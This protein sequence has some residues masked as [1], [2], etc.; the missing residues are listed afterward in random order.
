MIKIFPAVLVKTALFR[1]E[2]VKGRSGKNSRHTEAQKAGIPGRSFRPPASFP[3]VYVE[4]T[5]LLRSNE[6]NYSL[7]RTNIKTGT[8][9]RSFLVIL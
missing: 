6:Y 1:S 2:V 3:L 9:E 5:R 7:F 8:W 4:F